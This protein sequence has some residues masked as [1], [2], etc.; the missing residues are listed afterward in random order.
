MDAALQCFAIRIRHYLLA[1]NGYEWK[2]GIL[3]FRYGIRN[4][5]C[6]TSKYSPKM[7][8]N[9]GKEPPM[10]TL[11]MHPNNIYGHSFLFKRKIRSMDTGYSSGLVIGFARVSSSSSSPLSGW[12]ECNEG[13]M[14]DKRRRRMSLALGDDASAEIMKLWMSKRVANLDISPL[15]TIHMTWRTLFLIFR[16]IRRH[17]IVVA[18]FELHQFLMAAIF[19]NHPSVN[20]HNTIGI[21]DGR[22]SMR[23]H[24]CGA[25]LTGTIQRPLHTF[26][27]TGVQ[28]R[29]CLVQQQNFR[30]A[31]QCA[32][33]RNAL[34]LSTRQMATV[35]YFCVVT[36]QK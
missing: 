29:C 6:V 36:L 3:W 34:F 19:H 7:M 13:D 22:Q 26:L 18:T 15:N 1:M 33:N 20:V 35:R 30:I 12:L 24:N 17:Q 31:N 27:R 8:A 14:E 32:C 10:I 23:Y 28:C 21:C 11:P 4:H 9:V 16:V 5:C 2:F 25:T